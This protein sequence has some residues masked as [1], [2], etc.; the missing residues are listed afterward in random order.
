MEG[1]RAI[2]EYSAVSSIQAEREMVARVFANSRGMSRHAMSRERLRR[3]R[4]RAIDAGLLLLALG[5]VFFVLTFPLLVGLLVR[6]I[7][8]S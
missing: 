5:M 8:G 7:L 3:L 1:D 2:S 6:A 4:Q